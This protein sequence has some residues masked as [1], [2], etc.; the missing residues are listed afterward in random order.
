HSTH[1]QQLPGDRWVRIEER[2][3]AD[4]GSIGIRVDITDLKRR[5]ASFRLLFEENPLPMWVVDIN[6]FELLAVNAA[7]CRHYGY[8]REQ[9]LTMTVED[10]RVPEEPDLLRAEFR[11]HKG[12]Q[13]AHATRRHRTA[14]GRVI[15]VAIEARP[16][17]YNGREAAVAAAF[18]MTDRKRA[19]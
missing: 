13:F 11:E 10:L 7:T 19:E 18:D 17:R 9:M 2:R 16:L 5:E 1:E 8:A 15:D 12:T 3:T 4:G 6:S 14:D